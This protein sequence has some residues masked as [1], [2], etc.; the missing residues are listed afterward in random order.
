[1]NISPAR[2]AL[3]VNDDGDYARFLS[4]LLQQSG[5]ATTVAVDGADALD[6]A[7]QRDHDVIVSDVM[8]P[9]MDGFGLCRA[10]RADEQLRETPILLVTALRKGRESMVEGLNAGADDFLELP[11]DPVRLV[12]KVT[13][14]VERRQL[15]DESKDRLRARCAA[16]AN[17]VQVREE[18][19]AALSRRV[20]EVQES[21]RRAVARELHDEI[22]QVLTALK[23]MLQTPRHASPSAEQTRITECIGMADRLLQQVRSLS[24]DLRPSMLDHLGL[25]AT[26][27]WYVH[28]EVERGR[29]AAEMQLCPDDLRLSSELETTL[30]RIAQEALTNVSRHA[31]AAAVSVSLAVSGGQ[32]TLLVRDTGH[33]FDVEAARERGRRGQSLGILGMEER[34]TLAGGVLVLRSGA[35]GTEVRATFP[36]ARTQGSHP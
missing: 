9:R 25:P 22:G 31:N 14:L 20:L 16:L 28:R 13:R 29:F 10:V 5:F 34:A 18:R 32:V 33:G 8:M 17:L 7:R 11:Y 30:F 27:R 26:L 15:E 24:L 35:W 2:T 4:A 3:I 6:K 23:L 12:A 1:M 36:W 19:L 21:E